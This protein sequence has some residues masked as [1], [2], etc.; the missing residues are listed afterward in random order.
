[1]TVFYI[2]GLFFL[3]TPLVSA[4]NWKNFSE[5]K[6]RQLLQQNTLTWS[7]TENIASKLKAIKEILG[8][9]FHSVEQKLV[10]KT[11]LL[12]NV[13]NHCYFSL[14]YY[15]WRT[16]G[17]KKLGFGESKY[18]ALEVTQYPPPL[19]L[20]CKYTECTQ[21]KWYISFPQVCT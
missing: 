18:S 16:K 10:L 9:D 6:L 17:G 8:F 4:G 20:Y 15:C 5:G 11:N 3:H 2:L 12:K 14:K 13:P 1:M 21:K 7:A 19:D